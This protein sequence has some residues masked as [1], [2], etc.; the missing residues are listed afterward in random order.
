M[1]QL[2][3]TTETTQC[4]CTL[5]SSIQVFYYYYFFFF[6]KKFKAET[7]PKNKKLK[8]E[9]TPP[10]T[11]TKKKRKMLSF[12][13]VCTQQIESGRIWFDA[14]LI[15]SEILK[16]GNSAKNVYK[17]FLFC[18]VFLLPGAIFLAKDVEDEVKVVMLTVIEVFVQCGSSGG[19]AAAVTIK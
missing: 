12:F 6:K 11:T 10:P 5:D 17:F 9:T 2:I 7:P 1:T 13:M 18:F 16:R 19:P 3:L 8:A 4:F 14:S 15:F